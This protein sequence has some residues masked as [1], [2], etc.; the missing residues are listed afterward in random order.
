MGWDGQTERRVWRVWLVWLG[1]GMEEVV[2]ARRL[3][4]HGERAAHVVLDDDVVRDL[5][6]AVGR[7]KAAAAAKG[8]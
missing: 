8:V 2:A 3:G 1:L 6:A 7:L 4:G 5:E